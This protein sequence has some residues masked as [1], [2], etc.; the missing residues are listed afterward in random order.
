M[1]SIPLIANLY[2]KAKENNMLSGI[3]IFDIIAFLSYVINPISI[4]Y[5]GDID[6]IFGGIVAL[7]FAL[8]NR[9]ENQIAFKTAL[10]V[11]LFGAILSA[12]SISV[13]EWVFFIVYVGFNFITFWSLLLTF[14]IIAIIVGLVLGLII[15]YIYYRKN[16]K[17][18]K[19][20]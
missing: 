11:G 12:V 6:L 13:F 9:N 3:I 8:K 4:I 16:L 10:I 7:I 5:A 19:S 17:S 2:S 15:G 18:S 20:K 1:S 14:L